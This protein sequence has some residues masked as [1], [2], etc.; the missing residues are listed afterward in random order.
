MKYFLIIFFPFLLSSQ[1]IVDRWN[2]IP[3]EQ[4]T[5]IDHAC[6]FWFR[7]FGVYATSKFIYNKTGNSFK[8]GCIGYAAGVATIFLERGLYGKAVGFGG[9]TT[10]IFAFTIDMDQRRNRIKDFE[11]KRKIFE[12][13][14]YHNIY[15]D[16][17]ICK[18][19]SL[20]ILQTTNNK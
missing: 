1:S 11:E 6:D 18:I 7:A 14:N 20:K 17:L 19:D 5:N 16:T 2:K 12:T 9:A 15:H 4:R 10:G 3:Q 8:A 13:F